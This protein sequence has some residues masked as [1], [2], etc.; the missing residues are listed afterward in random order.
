MNKKFT[1]ML[2]LTLSAMLF[3]ACN[4]NETPEDTK[5]PAKETTTE[6]KDTAKTETDKTEDDATKEAEKETAKPVEKGE[7]SVK[8]EDGKEEVK[9]TVHEQA[10]EQPY[11][12]QVVNGYSLVQ[13]EPGIDQVTYDAN[14][15]I[16]MRI[17]TVKSS[18]SSYDAIQR[19]SHDTI[20]ATAGDNE[21]TTLTSDNLSA[22]TGASKIEGWSTTFDEHDVVYSIA[23]EKNGILGQITIYDT[24]DAKQFN[25][26]LAMAA[27][28]D[29]K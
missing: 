8:T 2:S 16:F 28:V 4:T 19:I 24:V 15:E 6:V 27:T 17:K 23:F 5:A 13:E 22:F 14:G 11:K 29:A 21:I 7:I 12:L 25:T 26:M 18:D 9:E 20:A 1:L 10:E 3:A